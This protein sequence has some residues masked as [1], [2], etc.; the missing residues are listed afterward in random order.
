MKYDPKFIVMDTET[1]G[2]PDR[3]KKQAT[4]EVALTEVACVVID[5]ESLVITEKVSWL[6]KPYADDLIYTKEAEEVSGISQEL[7]KK[8]GWDIEVVYN[9]LKNVFIKGKSGRNKPIVIFHNKP[10]DIPFIENLFLLFK[11]NLWNW[12]D[13][14]EDTMEWARVK[15]VENPKFTLAA[16]AEKCEIDQQQAHRALPDT[17]ITAQIVIKFLKDFRSEGS[18]SP[19][20]KQKKFRDHF[21]F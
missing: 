2:L 8:E 5:N 3:L 19:E 7:L 13:R 18:N 9:A 21:K 6:I 16:C 20:E 12:I 10:F 4:I 15:W 11:D 1:G 17:I 14:V